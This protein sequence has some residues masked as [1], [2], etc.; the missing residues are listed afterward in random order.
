MHFVDGKKSYNNTIP[1]IFTTCT[2][3]KPRKSP[4]VRTVVPPVLETPSIVEIPENDNDNNTED[5]NQLKDKITLLEAQKT[6]MQAKFD[7]DVENLKCGLFRIERFI[8]S[9][10]DFRFYTGFPNYSCFKA[11]YDYLSPGNMQ[12]RI[13]QGSC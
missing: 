12:N 2:T 10:S 13:S 5:T 6:A 9:D 4:A 11:F 7:K 8:S 1:T 3:S